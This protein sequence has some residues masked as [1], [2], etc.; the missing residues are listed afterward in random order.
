M[1]GNGRKSKNFAPD[2]VFPYHGLVKDAGCLK[3]STEAELATW[4]APT[5]Q[6]GMRDAIS[7]KGR[8]RVPIQPI[9]VRLT[10]C[11]AFSD[12]VPTISPIW[13]RFL[14]NYLKYLLCD[15]SRRDANVLITLCASA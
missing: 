9:S 2:R 12:K 11:D 3:A 5:D 13:Q 4:E 1:S 14:M 6:L 8:M 7:S 15:E 10:R